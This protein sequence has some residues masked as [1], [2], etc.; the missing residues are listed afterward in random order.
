M[1]G[2][3]ALQ[4]CGAHCVPEQCATTVRCIL[5]AHIVCRNSAPEKKFTYQKTCLQQTCRKFAAYMY[6]RPYNLVRGNM[7]VIFSAPEPKSQVHNCDQALSVILSSSAPRSL[8]FHIF[9]F[10]S[11][12]AERNLPKL[13]RKQHLNILYQVCVF[14][15][16]RKN[17][18]AT[19]ASDWLGHFLLFL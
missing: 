15:A 16:D 3:C 14:R 7:C 4:T 19:L 6:Q 13:D 17:K 18:M 11:K 9:D 1:H 12:T 2:N 10:S 8:T 5:A